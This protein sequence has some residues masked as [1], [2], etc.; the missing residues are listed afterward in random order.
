VVLEMVP[1][2]GVR[3]ARQVRAVAQADGAA[4]HDE[5]VIGA[6]AVVV[7]EVACVLDPVALLPSHLREVSIA[8]RLGGDHVR[9]RRCLLAAELGN[10]ANPA[11]HP[12]PQ[13]RSGR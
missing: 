5:T 10:E 8:E 7:N 1:R 4:A 6:D 3:V 13:A 12:P 9:P 2:G 11:L